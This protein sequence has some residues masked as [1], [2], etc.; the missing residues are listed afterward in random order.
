[1]IPLKELF[2]KHYKIS[3]AADRLYGSH[4]G[5]GSTMEYTEDLR[6]LIPALLERY[7]IRS[8]FDAGCGDRNW[9]KHT[10]LSCSYLG[11]D[12]AEDFIEIGEGLVISHDITVDPIPQVDLV[13]IRDVAIHLCDADRLKLLQNLAA[14]NCRYVLMTHC[15][16]TENRDVNYTSFPFSDVNWTIQP[17]SLPNPLELIRET[18]NHKCLALW[19]IQQ[20]R[21]CLDNIDLV[22]IGN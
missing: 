14:S 3:H 19:T 11:G 17:W 16:N 10:V 2:N 8:M 20:I 5:P 7:A 9:M 13:F 4:C 22:D 12:L 18:I 21:E 15:F 6:I 1:M